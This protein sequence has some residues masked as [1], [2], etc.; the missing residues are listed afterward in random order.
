MILSPWSGAAGEPGRWPGRE[1]SR[2]LIH[3]VRRSRRQVAHEGTLTGAR[4]IKGA[5]LLVW[6]F[7][8]IMRSWCSCI[9]R[10]ELGRGTLHHLGRARALAP[11]PVRV[12]IG[13]MCRLK[14][15]FGWWSVLAV[16]VNT[17]W[18]FL[19]VM[20]R[21]VLTLKRVLIGSFG[22]ESGR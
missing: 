12:L 4:V 5:H 14:Q 13:L 17:T 18:S 9:Q 6:E 19:G 2:T 22:C 8:F 20:V 7:Q 11:E 15:L 10:L 16:H 1:C 3:G 21:G